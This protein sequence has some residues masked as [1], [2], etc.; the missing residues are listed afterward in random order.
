M[1]PA[2]DPSTRASAEI[3]DRSG[4]AGAGPWEPVGAPQPILAQILDTVP[5]PVFWKDC[6]SVYLG[7]NAAFARDVGLRSTAEIVGKTDFDLPGSRAEAESYRAVDR[8]VIQTGQP[9]RHILESAQQADGVPQWIDTTKVPLLTPD[10][11]V[12]GVLGIY[13]DMTERKRA[14]EALRK[15]EAVLRSMLE[16]APVGV[17]LLVDRVMKKVNRALCQMTGY[18]EAELRDRS[19]RVLYPTAAEYERVGRELYGQMR[20]AGLGALEAQLQ[21][22]DGT[23]IDALLCLS[24][25]DPHDLTAG[26]TA[27]VL[28]I[29]ERRRADE[30]L[31]ESEHR[32]RSLYANMAEGVAL[33]ELVRDAQGRAVDYR[34]IDVN[35]RYEQAVGLSAASVVGK[36]AAEAYGTAEPPYLREFA[37]TL[38][39][40]QPVYFET[41]FAPLDKHFAISAAPL[42]ADRFATIFFDIT[43]R[44]RTEDALKLHNE[45]LR[46]IAGASR[47]VLTHMSAAEQFAVEA[48]RIRATFGVDLCAIRTLQGDEL[49]LLADDGAPPEPLA[50]RVSASLGIARVILTEQQALTIADVAADPRTAALAAPL[51]GHYAFMSYAGAP[52]LHDGKAIG[53]LGIFTARTRRDFTST[54][55]EHLQIVANNIAAAIVNQ[56]LYHQVTLQK[57]QLEQELDQRQRLEE[58]LRQS[59]KM[60]A[61]GQLA[62]GVAHD[63]NNILT[64]VFGHVELALQTLETQPALAGDLLENMRQIERSADRAS[65]LTRQLLAF[66]RRQLMRLEV[67]DLNTTVRSLEPMLRR[68]LTENITLEQ[69]LA[70]DLAPTKADAGQLEQVVVNLVINACDAMRHGGHLTLE[71]GNVVLDELY[72]ALHPGAQT[73]AHVVL[74]VSDTGC[75]MDGKTRERIFEPFFTTKPKGQGTGLGLST[76]YGIVKQAGG[77]VTVYSE[78][79]RGSSFK[80]YLPA[81]HDPLSAARPARPASAPPRGTETL[82]ICEDDV[83]VRELTA[84]ILA[85]GGYQV[86]VAQDATHALQLAAGHAGPI[87]LL[88]TDVIMPGMN[89][90]QLSESLAV[91]RPGI[92]TLFVSGYTSDVIAHHGVLD[93]NVDF[94][95][96]PYSR[97]QLLQKIREILDRAEHASPA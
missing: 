78:P 72:A 52:L 71:T 15:S 18:S 1:A 73:G 62:G 76:V 37:R 30:K 45:R 77:H 5:H 29:T 10:G 28:D 65:S 50:E 89:G 95:E 94:L 33:H 86:L 87:P 84:R 41:Y 83:A 25:F 75:G 69:I 32:F 91:L 3:V 42:E 16:A 2:G 61:I 49:V 38:D 82:I 44:K 17:G 56:R 8:A 93:A 12:Y 60:E 27:A 70:E 54:D 55:L 88:L 20:A 47:S 85:G 13:H 36:P 97:Q 7:C 9:R 26:V 74:T 79:G 22:K 6:Q 4:A 48:R 43:E 23:R 11:R 40:R 92:R 53:I 63:F 64:A 19:A 35:P 57:E 51:P 96:K 68:L 34:V 81:V 21:R 24:P 14:E 31:R 67:L 59:Q 39:T 46:L 90:R 66:S 80:V 58:Q